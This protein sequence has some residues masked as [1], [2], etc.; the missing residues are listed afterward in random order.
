MCEELYFNNCYSEVVTRYVINNHVSEHVPLQEV[1]LKRAVVRPKR[2][3]SLEE[4]FENMF[5]ICS[6]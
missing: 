1:L 2:K 5:L 6:V 3:F 4:L